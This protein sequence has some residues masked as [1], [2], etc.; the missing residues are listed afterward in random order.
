MLYETM[1][2]VVDAYMGEVDADLHDAAEGA[3]AEISAALHLT[4][5]C[6][7]G[8]AAQVRVIHG[9]D[10]FWCAGFYTVTDGVI[11]RGVEHWVTEGSED[12]PEW[13]RRFRTAP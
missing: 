6:A 2:S 11:V 5:R 9:D 7:E 8:V 3:T 13:R 10:V 1:C 12:P 4:R